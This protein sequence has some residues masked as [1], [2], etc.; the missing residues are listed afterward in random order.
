MLGAPVER[1]T[2]FYFE[3]VDSERAR[4]VKAQLREAGDTSAVIETNSGF[5][6]FQAKEI[7]DEIMTVISVSIA[8]RSYEI[9]LKEQNRI[10]SSIRGVFQI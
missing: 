4:V 8:K 10:T 7:T 9:W 6:V 1:D 3:D 5:I 2:N